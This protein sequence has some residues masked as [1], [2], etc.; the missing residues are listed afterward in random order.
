MLLKNKQISKAQ[1]GFNPCLLCFVRFPLK[2]G[3]DDFDAKDLAGSLIINVS[4]AWMVN[5]KN[6]FRM[7]W[8]LG[9]M[10]PLLVYLMVLLP[11]R[12]AFDNEA[13]RFT[14]VYWFDF[15]SDMV[16]MTDIFLNFRTGN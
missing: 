1:S 4:D 10:I 13:P 9:V 8:D 11:F 14:W 6:K 5:P 16:A 3:T 7:V 15:F 12:L 2:V